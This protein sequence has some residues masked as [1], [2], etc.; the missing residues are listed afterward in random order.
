MNTTSAFKEQTIREYV[1]RINWKDN[2]SV[3]QIKEDLKRT[4][5]EV[6][7]VELKWNKEEVINEVN[8]KSSIKESVKS[9]TIA[10]SDGENKDGSPKVH[11]VTYFI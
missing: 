11:S 9:I 1:M 4:I 6:P 7:G 5:K 2:F 10:Y 8:G 3:K